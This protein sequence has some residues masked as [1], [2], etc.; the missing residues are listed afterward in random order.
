MSTL[1]LGRSNSE[2]IRI[3]LVYRL[4]SIATRKNKKKT[5]L[6]SPEE[7]TY[8]I[9]RHVYVYAKWTTCVGICTLLNVACA[10]WELIVC[11]LFL[12]LKLLRVLCTAR[13]VTLLASNAGSFRPCLTLLT[14]VDCKQVN[15]EQQKQ[16][17]SYYH[18]HSKY[19]LKNKLYFCGIP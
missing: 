16:A 1:G 15:V 19:S 3:V 6:I 17:T 5:K 8:Q 7:S 11:H 12:A 14:V 10:F 2:Q 13:P 18:C 4:R 9:A